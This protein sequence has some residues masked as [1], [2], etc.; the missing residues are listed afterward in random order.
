MPFWSICR[1]TRLWDCSR[2]NNRSARSR[3]Y[4]LIRGG[5]IIWTIFRTWCAWHCKCIIERLIIW[6]IGNY[7]SYS[8]A[9]LCYIVILCT[10]WALRLYKSPFACICSCIQSL[11]NLAFLTFAR[12]PIPVRNILRAGRAL[13][14]QRV[15]VRFIWW[16]YR[17]YCVIRL[18]RSRDL[19][20]F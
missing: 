17:Y 14:W 16:T 7:S 11:P 12:L 2:D 19:L 8:S 3:W 20:A 6:A 9:L 1:I 18:S 4:T 5:V 15:P 10:R 13:F